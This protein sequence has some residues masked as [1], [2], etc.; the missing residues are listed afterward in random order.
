MDDDGVGYVD[1]GEEDDYWNANG[2]QEEEEEE[3]AKGGKKRKGDP[4]NKGEKAAIHL[5][6]PIKLQRSIS[7]DLYCLA[8]GSKAKKKA[9]EAAD[10]A[11]GSENIAKLFSKAAAR[12]TVNIGARAVKSKV[13][14]EDADALLG[15]LLADLDASTGVTAPPTSTYAG[16]VGMGARPAATF[17][18]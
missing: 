12:Q 8:D 3:D 7:H 16:H 1:V 6:G 14:D 11:A 17:G 15:D 18:R 2:D 9:T 5:S 10:A 13:N 4:K